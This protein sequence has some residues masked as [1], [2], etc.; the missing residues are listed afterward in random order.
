MKLTEVRIHRLHM[1]LRFRFETSFGVET[2]RRL[3]IVEV[4]AGDRVGYGECVAMEAPVYNEETLDGARAVLVQHLLPRLAGAELREPEDVARLLAPVHGNRM[5]KAAVECAVW[6][7]MAQE[8]GLPLARLLGGT[9]ESVEVGVSLGIEPDVDALL[10]QVERHVGQGYRRIKLKVKPG[11][12]EVPLGEV[13]AA[14]PDIALTVD[15]NTAYRADDLG[16]LATWDRFRLDY[17]EQPFPEDDLLLHAELARRMETAVCLDESVHSAADARLVAHLGAAR[18]IN[19]KVGRVGGLAET[20]RLCE[21]AREHGIALWCGGMLETGVGRAVNVAVAS[22]PEFT[23]P[24]D[25][26]GSERYWDLD[27]IEPPV[28]V[29]DGRIPVPAASGLGYAVVPE[30]LRRYAVEPPWVGHLAG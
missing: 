15:A 28:V 2:H 30:R 1:P 8:R 16:R 27:L 13:R 18:V 25:T 14:F 9:K 7:L 11:W 24:G 5:A 26:A 12:D 6:D 23:M 21:V 20:L 10:S 3:D 29:T 4:R 19:V 17:I 22:R